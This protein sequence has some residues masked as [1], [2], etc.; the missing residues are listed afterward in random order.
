[1]KIDLSQMITEGRN[2]ASQNIDE[3]S[4]EAMLRV[5]ND[6]DKKV[7]LAVEAIV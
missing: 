2:P 5:I 4:T 3:L 6:E 1:M 7:A